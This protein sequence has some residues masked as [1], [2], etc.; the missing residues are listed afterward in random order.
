MRGLDQTLDTAVVEDAAASTEP[1]RILSLSCVYPNPAEPQFGVFVRSRLQ[2]ISALAAV[3]VLAPIA[4]IDYAG[5]SKR[6]L[7]RRGIP[8]RR[9]DGEVEVLHPMWLYPPG[10]GCLN[11]MLLWLRLLPEALRLRRSF[12]FQLIDAHFG[13]PEGIAACM[14]A[15]TLRLPFTITLRGNE[16]MHAQRRL[17]GLLMR[18][19]IRNA[20]R[21]ITVSQPL[22]DSALSAGA[23]R[24]SIRV[25]P[26]GVDADIFHPR[27]RAAC[28]EKHGLPADAK[29]IL[30]AGALIERKGHHRLVRAVSALAR[31]GL[32]CLLVIAGGSGREGQFAPA[33]ER[34][35]AD[36]GIQSVVRLEGHVPPEHMAELMCAADL[37]ALASTREGWPNVVHEAM[38][39]GLPVVATGVGAVPQMIAS[40]AYGFVVPVGDQQLLEDALRKALR[41]PWNHPE[42]AAWAQ[43]RTWTAVARE[44]VAEMQKIVPLAKGESPS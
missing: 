7:G 8:P 44:V 22:G 23:P 6:R 4:A 3:K 39:C 24:S 1:L 31:E 20:Q 21:V 36:A 37:L 12:R 40:D 43:S 2:H 42:I 9:T 15:K 41:K 25:I 11:P 18:W 33:I 26:N 30:S 19:A 17:R 29:V 13:H 28:R 32:A 27:D 5:V 34:A 16:T 14:L 10:G 38:A 35:I